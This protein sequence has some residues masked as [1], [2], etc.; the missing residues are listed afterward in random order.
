MVKRQTID[1][2]ARQGDD[3]VRSPVRKKRNKK[4]GSWRGT[5]QGFMQ[6][7]SLRVVPSVQFIDND[8]PGPG[9]YNVTGSLVKQ[10]FNR[11]YSEPSFVSL[12]QPSYLRSTAA[13]DVKHLESG[14]AAP[15]VNHATNL[16]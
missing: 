16:Q 3:E 2:T 11:V 9:A 15:L 6:A 7:G 4:S 1:D 14:K 12:N 10:S 13:M 8:T 5:A